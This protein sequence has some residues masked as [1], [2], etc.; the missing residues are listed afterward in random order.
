MPPE[1]KGSVRRETKETQ[2]T[3]EMNLDGSGQVDIATGI[4]MLDHLLEQLPRH[5]LF[6]IMI[7]ASGDI[8]RDPHHLIEDVGIS[9]GRALAEALGERR[10]IVRMAHAVVPLDEALALVAVDLSGRGHA[11]VD[12]PFTS[13][14]IGELPTEMIAHH[15]AAFAVEGRFNL[16]VR[17]LAG[18]NDHHKAEAAFKALARALGDA[19]RIDPRISDIPSTKGTL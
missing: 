14:R 1:R 7:Q 3:V 10:G 6:D 12:L 15:L 11:A 4:G 8:D 2:V 19:T 16:H 5:S 13:D 9:L 17:V 18:T